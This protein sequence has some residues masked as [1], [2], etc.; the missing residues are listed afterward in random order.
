MSDHVLS[1]RQWQALVEMSNGEGLKGASDRMGITVPTLKNHLHRAYGLLG[2]S[3]I[4]G[5]Y[6][7]LG[8]LRAGKP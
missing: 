4:V 2:V 5:A 7:K 3:G 8:W 1:P 6:Y